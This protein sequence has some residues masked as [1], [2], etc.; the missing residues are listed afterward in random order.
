V[1]RELSYPSVH[2][3]ADGRLHVAFTFHRKAIEHVVVDPAWV[4]AG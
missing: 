1:N 3:T 4:V 2:Q